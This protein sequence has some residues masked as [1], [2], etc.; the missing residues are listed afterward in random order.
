MIYVTGDMHGDE[1]RL[2]DSQWRK[3]KAGDV[4]IICGDFGFLWNG[5]KQ[6]QQVIEWLGS[7]KYTVCFVD[8]THENFEMINKCRETVWKGGHVHRINHNLF[9]LMRGQIFNIDGVKIFTFGG[10]ESDDREERN[11][12]SGIWFRDEMPNIYDFKEGAKNL[13]EAGLEVD[14]IITHEPSSL[15]KSSMLLRKGKIDRVNK[16]NGYFEEIGRS[17]KF[18]H[19]YFGSLHE[20]RLVTPNHTCLFEKMIPLGFRN[21]ISKKEK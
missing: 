21:Q 10:G 8:G 7:R 5:T 11:T 4:V 19:W 2:Y 13:D 9:H 1:S 17:C 16:L 15:V 20:D 12:E 3:L 18:R 14:Y 6:E